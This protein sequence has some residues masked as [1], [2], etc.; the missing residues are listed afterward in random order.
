MCMHVHWMNVNF[1]KGFCQLNFNSY[2]RPNMRPNIGYWTECKSLPQYCEKNDWP[3]CTLTDH[4]WS[5]ILARSE[6]WLYIDDNFRWLIFIEL[7][8]LTHLSSDLV[9][10]CRFELPRTRYRSSQLDNEKYYELRD[11]ILLLVQLSNLIPI[12]IQVKLA[13]VDTYTLV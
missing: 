7:H 11:K 13:K 2:M 4:L 8:P 5:N 6:L 12:P 3:K 9:S 1:E 10:N